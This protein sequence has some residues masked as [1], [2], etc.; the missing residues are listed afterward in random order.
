MLPSLKTPKRRVELDNGVNF[1]NDFSNTLHVVM[2]GHD[3][4]LAVN[5]GTSN[6]TVSPRGELAFFMLSEAGKKLVIL[7][8]VRK[9]RLMQAPPPE[10][11]EL[12]NLLLCEETFY[13]AVPGILLHGKRDENGALLW[14]G[15]RAVDMGAGYLFQ[16]EE[17][18]RL[19]YTK[20]GTCDVFRYDPADR[21]TASAPTPKRLWEVLFASDFHP[22]YM[23][24]FSGEG[25]PKISE[26]C[27]VFA[28]VAAGHKVSDV[29]VRVYALL[30]YLRPFRA[31]T[32]ELLN[33]LLALDWELQY[34]ALI[35]EP[36]PSLLLLHEIYQYKNAAEIPTRKA[37]H[38]KIIRW[39]RMFETGK[40]FAAQARPV[41][42]LD[43]TDVNV[44]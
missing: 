30:S 16:L 2:D 13:A 40:R 36:F 17:D 28:E 9:T 43:Y 14:T 33:K 23:P 1:Y 44:R 24:A 21:R 3:E 11:F 19:S 25:F 20:R 10:K 27:D 26:F 42:G 12:I 35:D 8:P 5:L 6:W 4:G 39:S 29:G 18:G 7:D 37:M 22:D 34:S 38:R 41:R 15:M 31:E 32:A